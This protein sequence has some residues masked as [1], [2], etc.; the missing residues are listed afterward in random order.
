MWVC[1]WGSWCC[2]DSLLGGHRFDGLGVS[3]GSLAMEESKDVRGSRV[4]ES[5]V[6]MSSPGGGEIL[7]EE[8]GEETLIEDSFPEGGVESANGEDIMVKVVGSDVYVDGVSGNSNDE[9]GWGGL[10]AEAGSEKDMKFLVGGGGAHDLASHEAGGLKTEGWDRGT[11]TGVDGSSAVGSSLGEEAQVAVA[12]GVLAGVDCKEDMQGGGELV[13]NSV[14]VAGFEGGKD[15]KIGNGTEAGGSFAVQESPGEDTKAFVKVCEQGTDIGLVGKGVEGVVESA[16]EGKVAIDGLLSRKAGISDKVWNPGM[17]TAVASSSAVAKALSVGAQLVVKEGAVMPHGEGLNPNDEVPGGEA[18][19]TGLLCSEI[20]QI[21]PG[22]GASGG[23]EKDGV[24]YASSV[25][26][27]ERTKIVVGGEIAEEIPRCKVE[28]M[29]TDGSNDGLKSTV[30]EQKLETKIVV[31]T[32]ENNGGAAAYFM[33][34]FQP[35]E[36]GGSKAPTVGEK[37]RL[38]PKIGSPETEGLSE[39]LSSSE[40]DLKV[41]ADHGNK[42]NVACSGGVCHFNAKEVMNSIDSVMRADGNLQNSSSDNNLTDNTVEGGTG[43]RDH[44]EAYVSPDE[45]TQD[46]EGG[47]TSPMCNE[48]ILKSEI[49][50]VRSDDVDRKCCSHEKDQDLEVVGQIGNTKIDVGACADPESFEDQIPAEISQLNNHGISITAIEVSNTDSFDR[51]SAFSKNNENLQVETVISDKLD[52]DVRPADSEVLGGHTSVTDGKEVAEMDIKEAPSSEVKLSGNDA[53]VGNFCSG[54][55]QGVAGGSTENFVESDDGQVN[56]AAEGDNAGVDPMDTSSP[57]TDATNRNLAC[58]KSIP[59]ADSESNG[60]PTTRS[61]V[62][63]GMVVGDDTDFEVLKTDVLYGNSSFTGYQNLKVEKDCGSTEKRLSQPGSVSFSEGTQVALGGEVAASETEAVRDSEAVD[64]GMDALDGNLSG[65]DEANAMQVDAELVCKQSLVVQENYVTGESIENAYSKDGVSERDTLDKDISLSEK[66]QELKMGSGLGST[67]LEPG[68]HVGTVSN[69]LEQHTYVQDEKSDIVVQSDR[70]FAHELDGDPSVNHSTA[71]KMS[72][73]VSCVTAVSNSVAEVA[74]GSQGEVNIFPSHDDRDILSSCTTD[75]I[76]D[77]PGGNQGS[78]VHIASNY[79]SLPDGDDAMGGPAHD[80]VISPETVKQVLEAKDQPFNIDENNIIE[81]NVP[82]AKVSEF[83]ENEGI[84]GRLVVDLDSGPRRDGNWNPHGEISHENIHSLDESYHDEDDIQGTMDNLSFDAECLEVSI[85]CDDAQMISDLGQE[86]EVEGEITEAEHICLQEVQ[87]IGSDEQGADNENQKSLE[88]K[89]LKRAFLKPGTL[90]R[91]PQA[92]YELPPESEGEFFVSD[93]VWGKVRSHPWWPGQIFDPSDASEKAM[94]YYRKDCFLVAYFGDRTFAWNEA[95]LLKPFRTHFS[96]IVKQSNSEVFHNAVDCA[97]DEVSRRVEFGLACSCM[98]KDDYDEIK[99]Q[100][101]ENAG[102]R[103]ESSRRD[104]ANKSVTLG[105]LEPDKFLEYI[106][107]LAQLASSG[108]DQL[109]LVI[110]KAQLLAFSRLKGY[111]RLPEFQYCGG[112]QE[113]DEDISCYNEM[114][115]HETDVLKGDD[116]KFK[117]QNSYPHKRKH[118]LKDIAYPRKKERS[119]SE[120]MGGMAYSPDDENDSDGKTNS[121]L[122]SSCGRKRK[123]D[124]FMSDSVVQDRTESICV[125]KVSNASAPIPRQSF[126]VGDCIRRAASQLTGSPL[127]LK[128]SG[129]RPQKLIDGSIGKLGGPGSD[130][131]STSPEDPQTGRTIIPMEYPSLDEMLSQLR[132]AARDP[133][134]GYSFLDTILIFF[135][136]FRNSILRGRSS[137]RETVAMDKV[138]GNRKKKSLHPAGSPEEFE[139][140]DMNDTYWTDRVIQNTSEEQPEQPDQ[141]T[142]SARKRK[143]PHPGSTDPE[144]SLQLGRRSYSRKRYSDGNHEVAVEKPANNVDEKERGLLPAELILNFPEVDSVPSEMILNKMFRRF[145]PLKESETEVDRVTSRARVVFKRCSDAEV[146]F[147][148]AGMINI[149]APTH[150]NYQLSYSPS[151]LFTPIPIAMEQ[152]PDVES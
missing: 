78:E 66:D 86:T 110:A 87:E 80:L 84:L 127:I 61:A 137:G 107:S 1:N 135:S 149:F 12:E 128:C 27:I 32:L 91:G 94:K 67:K 99:S 20:C 38:N 138:A 133:M 70:I 63:E 16:D 49:E 101:V 42:E 59:C 75:V 28:G 14:G 45:Q 26:S 147:S 4:L 65:P 95:S 8:L 22:E 56:I 130:I 131:S 6:T 25:L 121:K 17:E 44:S 5:A 23:T 30:E 71:Q 54:K 48:K 24:V 141:P 115:E 124:S 2:G 60:E 53:L 10:V 34:A 145:G 51:I 41:E 40:N 9:S 100:I 39:N 146:A 35:T 125:A 79:D 55:D 11:G 81:T 21:S 82:D 74:V 37:V 118:N 88:E 103:P 18:S 90:I 144:K 134:K 83:G 64:R 73:Q 151:T 143:E 69:N 46:A 98:P 29:E 97:L 106:K 15:Q 119:L 72:D 92:T 62:G 58:P 102:I 3:S 77:F 136:E 126:K 112:L 113:S 47:E 13:G 111:N 117:I 104:D 148:S 68:V 142:R 19:A 114:M 89:M 96:Q 129:E 108:A 76:T 57:E 85:A 93:L 31:E 139:F 105:L 152:E 50:A 123:G 109:E 7:A 120:L 36:V 132:L 33:S 43:T 52:D 116:E 122:I 150:V 140:E